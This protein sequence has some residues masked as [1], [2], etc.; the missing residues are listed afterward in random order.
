MKNL[1]DWKSKYDEAYIES[2][3]SKFASYS[4]RL[5][6]MLPI[7]ACG[8]FNPE[9]DFNG[10]RLQILS[11][12]TAPFELVCFNITSAGG[13]SVIALGWLG[14]KGRPSESFF[15]SFQS[16]ANQKKANAAFYLG[17]E[18]LE[19]IY[20]QPSWWEHQSPHIREEL[21]KRIRSGVG[22]SGTIRT[23]KSFTSFPYILSKLNVEDELRT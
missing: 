14:E 16:L 2:N 23:S 4:V 17:I 22:V 13:L 10:N 20:F 18:H 21:I 7:V 5:S 8:A 11:R 6:G 19:N 1:E 9:Y 12:G 3:F 15:N